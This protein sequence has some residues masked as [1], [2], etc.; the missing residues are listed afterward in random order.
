MGHDGKMPTVLI[1]EDDLRIRAAARK[2][3]EATG[4]F[5]VVGEAGAVARAVAIARA[6]RPDLMLLDLNLQDGSGIDVLRALSAD[7]KVPMTIVL[8]IFD[9]NAHIFDALR[10]GAMGYLL[11]EDFVARV[12]SSL[13]EVLAGGSPMS[14]SIARRV[15]TSF[16][17]PAA[18]VA[19]SPCELTP[20]ER[21][22]TQLLAHGSTYDEI[23]QLLGI[24]TNT[25]RTFIRSIY[26]KLHV[27][28]KTEAV[29][30]AMR[31]GVVPKP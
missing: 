3:L 8:T 10:A 2:L 26:E 15:L 24:S 23:G 28:S 17:E 5:R 16:R 7:G 12:T 20:R 19:T 31:L 18:N 6:E 14:P 13:D 22:V 25:V 4:R 27:S 21:E 9:D 11:K 1:V 29:R 30:E